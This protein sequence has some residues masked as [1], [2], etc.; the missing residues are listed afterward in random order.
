MF[1][2]DFELMLFRE[3]IEARDRKPWFWFWLQNSQKFS[4]LP[5]ARDELTSES[6][7]IDDYPEIS[8]SA[9]RQYQ[10][11]NKYFL[12]MYTHA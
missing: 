7:K 11:L 9:C 4:K 1:K 2:A 12:Y 8:W 5:I 6:D 3:F 10:T